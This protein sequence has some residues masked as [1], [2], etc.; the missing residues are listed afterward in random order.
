MEA[1][2]LI[3]RACTFAGEVLIDRLIS[4]RLE[5]VLTASGISTLLCA[6]DTVSYKRNNTSFAESSPRILQIL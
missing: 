6:I 1:T 3:S 5:S 2:R 4:A